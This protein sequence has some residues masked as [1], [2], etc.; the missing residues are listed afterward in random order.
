MPALLKIV[1]GLALCFNVLFLWN[2][3]WHEQR[4]PGSLSP[5]HRSHR[6]P[7]STGKWFSHPRNSC[8]N[9][10]SS[11]IGHHECSLLL[12]LNCQHEDTLK[13]HLLSVNYNTAKT[14]R[15]QWPTASSLIC[16]TDLSSN[17]TNGSL[18]INV[19]KKKSTFVLPL[20]VHWHI[21][22]AVQ[23]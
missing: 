14:A 17:A 15:T 19:D 21:A 7:L 22:P 11:V 12:N 9:S 18:C 20:L 10:G 5:L 23:T 4:L 8:S 1:D 3:R 2:F 16:T 6:L 13:Q